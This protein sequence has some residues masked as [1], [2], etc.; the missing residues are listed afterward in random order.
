MKNEALAYWTTVQRYRAALSLPARTYIA[1]VEIPSL[2][3]RVSNPRI[4]DQ[5]SNIMSQENISVED[6]PTYTGG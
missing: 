4:K 3:H 6:Q 1:H 5:L 2:F